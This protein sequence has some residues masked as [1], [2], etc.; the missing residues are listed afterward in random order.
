MNIM[1]IMNIKY[2]NEYSS[3]FKKVMSGYAQV[4]TKN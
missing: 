1:N 3:Q 2:Y 4:D